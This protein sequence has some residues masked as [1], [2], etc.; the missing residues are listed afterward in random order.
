MPSPLTNKFHPS[1]CSSREDGVHALLGRF[2]KTILN[3]GF[4]PVSSFS[5][6][7]WFDYSVSGFHINVLN[8]DNSCSYF[9]FASSQS[10]FNSA[11]S[12]SVCFKMPSFILR[13]KIM[14]I[15]FIGNF[16]RIF[17]STVITDLSS[18]PVIE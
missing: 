18:S 15:R 1:G 17:D 13:P 8:F 14:L 5:I 12:D 2:C 7:S 11:N 6:T 16:Q 3:Y 4:C 9:T 10:R